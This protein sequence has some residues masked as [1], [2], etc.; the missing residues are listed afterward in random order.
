MTDVNE[1]EWF[2]EHAKQFLEMA[3]RSELATFRGESFLFYPTFYCAAH[4]VE[5]AAKAH[6]LKAGITLETLKRRDVGHDLKALQKLLKSEVPDLLDYE[7]Q[8]V[9]FYGSKEY[10]GKNFE[11][12]IPFVSTLPIGNWI[13]VGQNLIKK[14]EAN[15]DHSA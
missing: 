7:A 8:Q 3:K 12:P 13:S 5:L 15:G 11:Y 6:L 14:F 4:A 9:M 2:I 10:A 1:A